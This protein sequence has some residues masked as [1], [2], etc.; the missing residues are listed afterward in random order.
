MTKK[1][2]RIGRPPTPNGTPPIRGQTRWHDDEWAEIQAA[3]KESGETYAEVVR[4]LMLK[5][6]RKS[7]AP[8]PVKIP[9]PKRKAKR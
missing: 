7:P 2:A 1:Q 9:A 8:P 3:L 5:W 6:A 4:R